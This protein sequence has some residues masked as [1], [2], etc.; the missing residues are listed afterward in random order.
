M[1]KCETTLLVFDFKDGNG[2]I[3]AHHHLNPDGSVSETA[4]VADSASVAETAWIL[5]NAGVGGNA[6]VCDDVLIWG[7]YRL[8]DIYGNAR[9]SGN[10]R[11]FGNFGI[12]GSMLI[13]DGNHGSEGHLWSMLAH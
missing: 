9:I 3:P 7:R 10:A 1:I 8:C 13:H 4:W 2:P 5:D 6:L 12:A 11:V